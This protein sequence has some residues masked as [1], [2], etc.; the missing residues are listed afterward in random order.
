MG[1][2]KPAFQVTDEGGTLL[3]II[4][5]GGRLAQ[6]ESGALCLTQPTLLEAL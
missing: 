4:Y 3:G 5:P 1:S 6:A 2:G